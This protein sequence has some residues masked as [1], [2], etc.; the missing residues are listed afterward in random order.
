MTYPKVTTTDEPSA[1]AATGRATRVPSNPRFP[2]IEERVLKYWDADGTFVASVENRDAGTDGDNEFVFYD[3][4]PFANG[5]PHYGHLLTGYVKDIVPRYQT[6]RGKRVERRFGWDT[7]GLPAELEAQRQLGLKT[8]QD[9]LDLGIDQFNEACRS[10]VLKYTGEWQEY[11][12]RQARW[13]DFDNDY[14]TL[15]PGYMESVIW[16]F[17]TLHDKGLVY[18]GFRVLPYCWNDQTPLSNHELRMDDDV[19]KMRQDPA[20]TI[21][22]RLETG[23]LALVWTTTPWTLPANLGIMVGPDIDYVVVESEASGTSERYVIG[24]ARLAAYAK[25]L[26]GPDVD[27]ATLDQRVVERLKGT[28]LLGRSFTP[29]MSYYLGHEHA[30][31]VFAADFVT[32]EDGTG[33]V[34]TAGAF[35]EEDK[36]VTDAAGIVPVM[37]VGPDGR[38]TYPVSDYEGMQVFDA[39]LHIIDHLKAATRGEGDTGSVTPGTVLLRRETYD[40]SYPHCWRCREPLIY[41]AVSSW[42]VEVTK[43]KDRMLEL[44]QQIEWTPS[45]IR[46]GQFGKWLAN[47]RDWSISRNR[48]WGSPIPVWKSDDP[49]YPRVDVYGS[50]AELEADFGRPVTDLHRPYIDELTRPNP[51][52]P[53]TPEQGQST[54]RRIEDVFDV[55]FDSGSMPYAQVHYPF[56]NTEWFEHHYPG[57]FIVE[58]IGQTRGWFYLMHVLATALF[59]RPAFKTCV[60]HGIVLGSDGQ[61][62]SKSLRNYPD[63]REVF[64]RDGA[65]AMRW[66]LMSSPILRGGNLIVTEQGIRDGVRQVMIPLWNAWSF[67]ALYANTAN[68]GDGYEATWSTASTDVLDRYLLAKL[69]DFVV[70]MQEQLDAYEIAAACDTMRGFLDVLTNWYIRRSRDRFWGGETAESH[71]AFDT[72]YTALETVTRAIAPLLPLVTEEIWRGLTGGRSVHLTDYPQADHLPADEA[73]VLAMDRAREV[74]SVASSLRKA[75]SLRARLPLARLTVVTPDPGALEPFRGIV[76]DEVNV[77]AL[78]LVDLA[79]ASE[80]D[81]GVSQR[82]TVNARVAGPRLGRNVQVAIKASKSGDWSVNDAVVTA[83]GLALV[84][85]EYSLET[86]VANGGAGTAANAEPAEQATAMLPGGGF[87][88]LDTA[89]TP[90]LATEGVA[91]DLVRAVQQARRD[92]GLHVSDRIRLTISG[93]PEVFEATVTH[94]EL[95]VEETLAAAFASGGPEHP[96]PAGTGSPVVVGDH[97]AATI[98]VVKA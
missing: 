54:M 89:V 81:F 9:I 27:L 2:D 57:D 46:D 91:R 69:H 80:A 60:S 90:A 32:T 4:P 50:F 83:G 48:F 51:D 65:D 62:M 76:C 35:G 18:E 55:W 21:G 13:V 78:D 12:T 52:D 95:I 66:F 37:P 59:D 22:L 40:H 14:K 74:C 93:E 39:N 34:H 30:H 7:H 49:R 77:K 53:R 31:R 94:R 20:V 75:R 68:G 47:A 42:F 11:V 85:G 24:A 43:F 1:D 61:K 88:A 15:D 5:L 84:E 28:D 97:H 86:V 45:H 63:V 41:M 3:G 58:Y 38:F 70:D 82:L 79:A 23:E 71:A 56:E 26:F 73:L 98:L 36:I 44:N 8:K 64:D 67:F 16:A 29:P 17:K 10:S 92:A 25:D 33:L 72:L 19:Y 6:M 87:V 96:L